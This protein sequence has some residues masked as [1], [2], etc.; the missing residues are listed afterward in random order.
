MR[1]NAQAVGV[2]RHSFRQTPKAEKLKRTLPE[3]KLSEQLSKYK[4]S[5][6]NVAACFAILLLTKIG[7]FSSMEGLQTRSQEV[8][9][10]YYAGH[11]GQDLADEIFPA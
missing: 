9:K 7:V 3:P 1:A 4:H 11:I 5:V 8:L 2:L 10:Q 6:A